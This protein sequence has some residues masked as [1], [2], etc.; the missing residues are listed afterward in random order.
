[1]SCI[2]TACPAGIREKS[3]GDGDCSLAVR[4]ARTA[5]VACPAQYYSP[6]NLDWQIGYL[7]VEGAGAKLNDLAYR[8][9]VN[10]VLDIGEVA[11]PSTKRIE[12]CANRRPIWN[13]AD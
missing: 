12:C 1:M 6:I 4:R 9:I 10:R 5:A 3:I 8:T 13:A 11:L 7:N 2:S